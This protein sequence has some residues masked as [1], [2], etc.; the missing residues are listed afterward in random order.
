MN[1]DCWYTETPIAKRR[2]FANSDR[3]AIVRNVRRRVEAGE[4]IRGACEALNIIPKQYREWTRMTTAMTEHRNPNAKSTCEGPISVL[5]PIEDEL[6][7]FIFELR[8]QG[9]AVSISTV[10]IQAS[11]LMPD[12]KRKSSLARYQCVRRWVRRHS[13]VHRMGTHESQRSPSETTGMAL[14]YV[15]TIRPR[16]SQSNRHQDFILNMDQTPV[17]FTF[18]AKK[19]LSIPSL[20]Q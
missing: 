7:K 18:N 17:P 4:S 11:R 14:D 5:M 8:E 15:Q 19:T 6:L 16:L 3:L 20:I 9:Y 12:F 1:H 10:V 2:R 13:L